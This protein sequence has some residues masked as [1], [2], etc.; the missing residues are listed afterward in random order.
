MSFH[1]KRGRRPALVAR[2]G[3]VLSA[4]AA[5]S[6]SATPSPAHHRVI[7]GDA[8]YYANRYVGRTMACGGTYQK[9][10]MVAAHRSLPCGTRVRIT[11]RSNGRTVR[12]RVKDRGPYGDKK[13]KFDV[14]RRAANRLRMI[15]AGRVPIKAVILHK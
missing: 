11:N 8:V 5:L 15:K 9:S 14:S 1:I 7:K 3:L 2:T 13:L 4:V 6:I 10:K 12:V